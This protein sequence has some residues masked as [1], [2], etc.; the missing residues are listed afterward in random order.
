VD[1]ARRQAPRGPTPAGGRGPPRLQA[2]PRGP[3]APHPARPGAGRV[4]PPHPAGGA[5]PGQGEYPPGPGP[6][7]GG[8]GGA[9]RPPRAAA[10]LPGPPPSP[11]AL[12]TRGLVIAIDGPSGAGK[13]T[14]G[15]ALAARLGYL[16]IDTGAM[17]RALALKAL[18]TGVP[19][20][21]EEA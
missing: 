9:A 21:A 10:G 19:L 13:S 1:P 2:A 14:A 7:P 16:Y 11:P 8:G 18:R 5:G 4:P 20:D 6:R 15:R 12:R 17:Y 3:G